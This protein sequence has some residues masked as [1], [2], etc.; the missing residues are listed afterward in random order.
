MCGSGASPE[1]TS[2][3]PASAGHIGDDVLCSLCPQAGLVH[4]TSKSRP[5]ISSI[6]FCTAGERISSASSGWELA[7]TSRA[8]R[9]SPSTFWVMSV[10][11]AP[12]AIFCLIDGMENMASARWPGLGSAVRALSRKSQRR[13]NVESDNALLSAVVVK[14]PHA[15]RVRVERFGSGEPNSIVFAPQPARA[16]ECRNT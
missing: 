14:L 4:T 9:L 5:C 11:S 12:G 6:E 1:K 13:H 15:R 3:V 10:N 8:R 2:S 7:M 16:S